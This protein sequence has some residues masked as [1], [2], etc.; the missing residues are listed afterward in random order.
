MAKKQA[1]VAA[2]Q[3]QQTVEQK[4]TSLFKLQE[5]D[6]KIDEI[7]RLRGELPLEVK[8]LEDEL[9]GLETR[10]S[11]IQDE[12]AQKE[13]DIVTKKEEIKDAQA[14][15]KKYEADAGALLQHQPLDFHGRDDR[16]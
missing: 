9:A 5:A 12:I 15:V 13:K 10:I 6:S 1:E 2:Q 16:I 7:Q 11:K 14:Q 8:D 4:L 3:A